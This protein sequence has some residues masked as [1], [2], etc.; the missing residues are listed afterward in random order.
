MRNMKLNFRRMPI[1]AIRAL[2]R[3]KRREPSEFEEITSEETNMEEAN[4]ESRIKPLMKDR[5]YREIYNLIKKDYMW[6]VRLKILVDAYSNDRGN[7]YKVRIE[8]IVISAVRFFGIIKI[9]EM[10]YEGGNLKAGGIDRHNPEFLASEEG[11]E[12]GNKKEEQP[13]IRYIAV[14]KLSRKKI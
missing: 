12:E 11:P 7:Q 4:I 6:Y 14:K 2:E 13:L 1:K 3:F 5:R 9:L 10:I 8:D